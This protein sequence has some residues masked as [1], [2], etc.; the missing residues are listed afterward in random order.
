MKKLYRDGKISV[1]YSTKKGFCVFSSVSLK[2]G[3]HITT[4][5]I[6]P[7]G[8]KDV[9]ENSKFN[10][11]PMYWTKKEDCVAFGVINLL[12]HSDRSNI[13]LKRDYKRKLINAYAIENISPNVELTINY[14][15]NLWF[16]YV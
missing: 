7:I 4:C 15:C 2:I 14:D 11:Y 10:D 9:R 3:E 13:C 8:F 6:S 5:A 12:N 1:W 16:K